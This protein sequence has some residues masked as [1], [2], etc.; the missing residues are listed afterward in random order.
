MYHNVYYSLHWGP[1]DDD[2]EDDDGEP[3]GVGDWFV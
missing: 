1:W 2:A 3:D